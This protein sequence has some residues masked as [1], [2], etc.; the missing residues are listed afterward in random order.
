MEFTHRVVMIGFGVVARTL[1]PLLLK[2]LKLS[3]AQ[4]VVIDLADRR[5]V[6]EPWI[7][8][9]LTFVHERITPFSLAR[10]L[11][12]HARAGDLIIDLAWSVD[13]FDIVQWARDNEVLYVNASL[14]SWNPGDEMER[15]TPLEKSLYARYARLL[16]LQQRW[17]HSTTALIDQ[18][19]NPGLIST[20]VK[21]GLLDIATA[22]LRENKFARPAAR[23][24]ERLLER[25]DFAPLAR[26]LGVR[27]IHCSECDTQ[28]ANVAKAPDEFVSTWS[29]EAMWEESISPCELGWG[30]HETWTPPA[31]TRPTTGPGNQ[32]I[33]PQMGLNSWVRSWVPQQ[34]IVGMLVTHGE[35]FSLSHTLSV[36]ARGRVVYRPT[37][38]Y[39]YMP[40]GDTLVSLHE[41]RARNYE[42]H[43]RTRVPTHELVAG[44]DTVGALIMGHPFKSWWTGSMLSIAEARKHVPGANATTVQVSAGVL[45]SVLWTLRN[46]RQGIRLPEDLPHSEILATAAPYLGELVSIRSDWTPLSRYRNY[47]SEET[48]ADVDHQDPWQFRNFLFRP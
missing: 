22:T 5:D 47:F 45:A 14:E 17:R 37:V 28:R 29:V 10:L 4:F 34:E 21:T 11:S 44:T 19:A 39:A 43:P 23:H 3:P 25:E 41:L 9:G 46:P 48:A 20:F 13:C 40:C 15:K 1:L 2:H 42:L 24:L 7:A 38:N 31:A 27:A 33:L 16:P 30:T 8:K 18:G 12:T 36:V 26:A 35:S 32:I 6:L